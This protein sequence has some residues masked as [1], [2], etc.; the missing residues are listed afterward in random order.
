MTPLVGAG[1][2]SNSS[3]G[4]PP[5]FPG[6]DGGSPARRAEQV[7]A[8]RLLQAG[9]RSVRTGSGRA[10][11]A[12]GAFPPQRHGAHGRGSQGASPPGSPGSEASKSAGSQGGGRPPIPRERGVHQPSPG[13][14]SAAPLGAA[15]HIPASARRRA[16]AVG[17]LEDVAHPVRGGP[18]GVGCRGGGPGT[19]SGHSAWRD[20]GTK[21]V[22][23]DAHPGVE[24]S[25]APSPRRFNNFG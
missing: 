1:A 5:G 17:L 4:A 19:G 6:L 21:N 16:S 2:N 10:P 25:F 12:S 9:P 18:R 23:P 8:R 7:L 14:P 15:P 11:V 24:N 20:S 13:Y 22:D 3:G